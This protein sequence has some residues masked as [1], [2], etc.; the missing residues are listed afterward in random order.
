MSTNQTLR[1]NSHKDITEKG[2]T[3]AYFAYTKAALILA[4]VSHGVIPQR[5]RQPHPVLGVLPLFHGALSANRFDTIWRAS[6]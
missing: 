6:L 2:Q 1:P 3:L 4:E 5:F